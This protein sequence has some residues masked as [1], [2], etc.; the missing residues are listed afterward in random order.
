MVLNRF[1]FM[2]KLNNIIARL[3]KG[4]KQFLLILIL[5]FI[6]RGTYGSEEKGSSFSV[7]IRFDRLKFHVNEPVILRMCIKNISSENADVMVFENET[8]RKQDYTTFQPVVLDMTG[9]E[10]E[11][12]VKYRLENRS[13]DEVLRGLKRRTLTLAPHEELSHTINL[14]SI[15]RLLPERKYR[16]K[17]YFFPD[18]AGGNEPS[19][20]NE[21]SFMITGRKKVPDLFK[22]AAIVHNVS[23]EEIVNLSLAAERE[24]NWKRMFKYYRIE[25]YI[26]S[27]PEYVRIFNLADKAGKMNIE[28]EFMAFLS[29]ERSDY[30]LD[31]NVVRGE[32][33]KGGNIAHVNVRVKRFAPGKPDRY[34][35]RYTLEKYENMWLI[36]ALEATVIK[37]VMR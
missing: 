14:R 15:Y 26:N 18:F 10:A 3:M 33:E 28:N 7:N 31:F 9:R 5:I 24:K 27:Y 32:I 16:V 30:I 23:P 8:N 25:K 13:R 6:V 34:L 2:Y 17:G 11:I 22:P 29:R 37:E 35:Y 12:I 1:I 4:K 20:S 36:V 21:I 19:L